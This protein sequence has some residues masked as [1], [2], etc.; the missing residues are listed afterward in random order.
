MNKIFKKIWSKTQGCMV[1]VSENA[2]SE[3]KNNTTTGIICED[4]AQVGVAESKTSSLKRASLSIL[5]V[6]VLSTMG[7]NVWA[8]PLIDLAIEVGQL[9]GTV[10]GLSTDL[11]TLTGTVGGL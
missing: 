2:K 8:D 10:G 3:G 11:G 5:A 4:S 7:S 6:G 1:V 9:T